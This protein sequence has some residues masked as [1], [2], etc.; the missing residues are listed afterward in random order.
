M[1]PVLP[2]PDAGADSARGFTLIETILVIV[3]GAMLASLVLQATH[4]R[5]QRSVDPLILIKEEGDMENQ[6]ALIAAEYRRRLRLGASGSMDAAAFAAFEGYAK[7]AS[8][9]TATG[10]FVLT[11]ETNVVAPL[12]GS[13]PNGTVTTAVPIFRVTL[14]SPTGE[15]RLRELYTR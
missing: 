7:T 14:V 3:V 11:A 9:F 10:N 15:R 8:N 2:R 13:G 12:T 5:L 4:Q 1:A 6:M